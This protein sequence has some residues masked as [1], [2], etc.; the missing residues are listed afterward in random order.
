[1]P[2]V[3][4][5]RCGVVACELGLKIEINVLILTG[6]SYRSRTDLTINFRTIGALSVLSSFPTSL[7]W[8][9]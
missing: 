6:L 9:S 2:M 3:D 5:W 8:F 4:K 1:M 7:F